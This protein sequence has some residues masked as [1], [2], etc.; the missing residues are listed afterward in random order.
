MPNQQIVLCYKH[1][2]HFLRGN[3]RGIRDT[4]TSLK[5][6][7]HEM[8]MLLS[9]YG[10]PKKKRLVPRTWLPGCV[11]CNKKQA[12]APAES[13]S[14]TGECTAPSPRN[15]DSL[16]LAPKRQAHGMES[17]YQSVMNYSHFMHAAH[18][19][20]PVPRSVC[21]SVICIA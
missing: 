20:L 17:R 5:L 6:Y 16:T 18:Q 11:K 19:G 7:S 13:S 15:F 1:T 9:M 12:I 8:L 21:E 10:T 2:R 14:L 3:M 4:G